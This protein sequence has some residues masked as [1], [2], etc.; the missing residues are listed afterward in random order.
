MQLGKYFNSRHLRDPW[1]WDFNA[2][3]SWHKQCEKART[4][5]GSVSTLITVCSQIQWCKLYK[6]VLQTALKT[7]CNAFIL[8]FRLPVLSTDPRQICTLTYANTLLPEERHS[9]QECGFSTLNAHSRHVFVGASWNRCSHM[10]TQNLD[11][12][13]Q[14]PLSSTSPDS[15]LVSKHV[16]SFCIPFL[17]S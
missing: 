8:K 2:A 6:T 17:I 5:P 15:C 7:H 3:Y 9:A 11:S 4:V 14:S 12:A 1:A 10:G 13:L 16:W